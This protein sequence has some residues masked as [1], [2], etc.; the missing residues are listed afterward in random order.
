MPKVSRKP[1]RP[2]AVTMT[3]WP[4]FIRSIQPETEVALW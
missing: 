3:A 4:R 2:E 1:R